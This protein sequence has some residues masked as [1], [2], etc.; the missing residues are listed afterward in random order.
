MPDKECG[1][2][3]YIGNYCWWG[4]PCANCIQYD[5]WESQAEKDT[6]EDIYHQ[7]I[8]KWGI[9]P[10]IIVA[11]EELSE[12]QKALCKYLRGDPHN[13]EEEIADVKIMTRQL[14]EMF[15][16]KAINDWEKAKLERLLQRIK[17]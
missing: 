8:Q 12:L 9:N 1:G 14:E 4:S 11:I 3:A 6:P 15:D 10:Q 5:N 16:S 13:V 2:C 7:A 17:A